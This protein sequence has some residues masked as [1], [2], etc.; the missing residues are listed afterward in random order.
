MIWH[1][2]QEDKELKLQGKHWLIFLMVRSLC[3]GGVYVTAIN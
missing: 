3:I 2:K 1:N